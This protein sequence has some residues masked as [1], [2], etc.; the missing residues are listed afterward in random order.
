[1]KISS[2]ILL[3]YIC[4]FCHHIPL[5]AQTREGNTEI[6]PLKIG[7]T[8]PDELWKLPLKVVNDPTGKKEVTLEQYKG[9]LILLDF[10][11]TFCTS[12]IAGFPKMK[13]IQEDNS[14][15]LKILA[16]SAEQKERIAKF[17]NSAVG[18]EYTYIN[19][20]YG[21]TKLD[22]YFPHQTI[23]HTVW[24]SRDGKY[25]VPTNTYEVT[26]E[27]IDAIYRN[28]PS[29]MLKKVDIKQKMPLL[30]SDNFYINNNLNLGFYS[31][32]F[33]GYYPGYPTGSNFKRTKDR[34]KVFGRQMTNMKLNAIV[35]AVASQLFTENKEH[36]SEKRI[37]LNTTN[38]YLIDTKLNFEDQLP[39]KQYYSYELIVPEEKADSLYT[40]MLADLNRYLDVTLSLRKQMTDCLVLVRTSKLDKFKSKGNSSGRNFSVDQGKLSVKDEPLVNLVSLL[41]DIP[42]SKLPVIDE[43]GYTNN[44]DLTLTGINNLEELR[45]SLAQYDL[46]L[47]EAK[48]DL[49]MFLVTDK[50]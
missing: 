21:D 46:D 43:T 2:I 49:L 19:S 37:I 12:C 4:L 5:Y 45:K 39:N 9:K 23:P 15:K 14:D 20:T 32:F 6:K 26:Q 24:I 22:K 34:K 13:K 17:F 50:K 41:N 33:Q 16:I 31:L 8:I 3:L 27:N 48:R 10:W 30:L 36:F 7:E 47:Q 28:Q 18:K 40:Y 11:G 35:R 1:M 25:V 42:L 29:T 38:P 44:I